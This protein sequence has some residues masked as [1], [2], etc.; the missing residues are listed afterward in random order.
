MDDDFNTPEA[1]SVL[2]ELAAEI[3]RT[4]DEKLALILKSLGAVMNILQIEPEQFLKGATSDLD[5]AQIDALVAERVE[6]KKARN[7]A[8]ADE[9]RNTLTAMGIVVE[10]GPQGS[11]WRRA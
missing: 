11:T 4:G 7:W 5:E 10:D 2:F 8:R 1:V 6:A 9:I 3:N